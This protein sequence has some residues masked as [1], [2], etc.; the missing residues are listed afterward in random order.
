MQTRHGHVFPWVRAVLTAA[1]FL[2]AGYLTLVR[3]LSSPPPPLAVILVTAAAI[4]LGAV[5]PS[6]QDVRFGRTLAVEREVGAALSGAFLT[7]ITTYAM[8]PADLRLHFFSVERPFWALPPLQE[9][10][11]RRGYFGLKFIAPFARVRWTK[12]KGIIG[13]VW[14]DRNIDGIARDVSLSR[15]VTTEVEWKQIPANERRN[16][17][18]SDYQG[19]R[20]IKTVYGQA[21]LDDQATGNVVGV[22]SA[23][24]GSGEPSAFNNPDLKN[25]LGVTG[26][27]TWSIV[28]KAG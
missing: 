24:T 22:I 1:S 17:S 23:D 21:I 9:R 14:Q 7:M 27:L 8:S 3:S 25:L 19:A 4:A 11:I 26:K 20:H 6:I 18:W 16:M 12:G 13:E 10:L 5:L 15:Q 2:A 28:K